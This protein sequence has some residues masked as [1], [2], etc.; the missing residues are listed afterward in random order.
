MQMSLSGK[1]SFKNKLFCLV[2]GFMSHVSTHQLVLGMRPRGPALGGDPSG[3][4]QPPRAHPAVQRRGLRAA[5]LSA[6][7]LTAARRAH[8]G[9]RP[10]NGPGAGVTAVWRQERGK[11]ERREERAGDLG[12]LMLGYFV[13]FLLRL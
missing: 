13:S 5:A 10:R 2:V 12:Q 7:L 3:Q 11:P 1:E 9:H 4:L 6:A 8:V